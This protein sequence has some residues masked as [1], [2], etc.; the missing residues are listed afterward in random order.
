[1]RGSLDPGLHASIPAGIRNRITSIESSNAS[2]IDPC[3]KRRNSPPLIKYG[4]VT[5]I[6]LNIHDQQETQKLE[7]KTVALDFEGS[8]LC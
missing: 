3:G 7:K 6:P 8:A 1:M 5:K 4:W 2:D